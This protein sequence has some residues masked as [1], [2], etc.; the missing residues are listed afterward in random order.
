MKLA[1][2]IKNK[3]TGKFVKDYNEVMRS[4]GL[5]LEMGFEDV[6]IQSDGTP[7][8]FDKCGSFGYLDTKHYEMVI[9]SDT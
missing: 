6:G 7:V 2:R 1:F 4:A 5:T 8:V 9:M 3:T